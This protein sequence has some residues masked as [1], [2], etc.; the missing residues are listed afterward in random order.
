MTDPTPTPTATGPGPDITQDVLDNV[1]ETSTGPTSGAASAVPADPAS[2]TAEDSP[3]AGDA[4]DPTV[5]TATS[6]ETPSTDA[7]D[8]PTETAGIPTAGASISPEADTSSSSEP[9]PVF[10]DTVTSTGT[11]PSLSPE[12]SDSTS[13]DDTT[14][15]SSDS[16][17]ASPDTSSSQGERP[18]LDPPIFNAAADQGTAP[19]DHDEH[20][21]PQP[22]ASSSA[23]N[24]AGE[25]DPTGTGTALGKDGAGPTENLPQLATEDNTGDVQQ[26]G[27]GVEPDVS[28]S[29][30]SDG[31]FT[32]SEA[33]E[34]DTAPNIVTEE[35]RTAE[36]DERGQQRSFGTPIDP[37][38]EAATTGYT[39]RF[40]GTLRPNGA[41]EVQRAD[42]IGPEVLVVDVDDVDELV[43][44]LTGLRD[45]AS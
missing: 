27:P 33:D 31:G 34:P 25:G 17:S 2:T 36:R 14:S 12:T 43:G 6:S 42:W 44:L 22:E 10:D 1:D 28:L 16:S 3:S 32:S 8:E 35:V 9:T 38:F 21:D 5:S 37:T 29:P 41:I 13:S 11:D 18:P 26:A 30:T 4:V 45:S 40:R 7:V 39:P 19:L 23:S 15:P 20:V 24:S